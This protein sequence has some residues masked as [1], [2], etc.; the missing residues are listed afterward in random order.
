MPD[1]VANRPIARALRSPSSTWLNV[2]STCGMSSAAV[3][4]CTMRAP[5]STPMVGASP[6]A[7]DVTTNPT[8]A[9]RKSRRRP[10]RSPRRPPSTSSAAY[11]TP[12]PA[13]TSS[14]DDAEARSDT[15][16]LGSATFVMKKS[17]IGRNAPASS[18]H[19]PAGCSPPARATV[20]AGAV[21]IIDVLR[22]AARG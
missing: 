9:A 20:R 3:A 19:T 15:S 7:S 12:Y 16:M 5:M 10:Y 11:A 21:V 14:S 22:G 8:S 13:T 18:A 2:A 4:P 17:M 1:V 6:Q